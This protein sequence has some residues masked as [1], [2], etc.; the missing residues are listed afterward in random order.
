MNQIP[1]LLPFLLLRDLTRT[2]RRQAIQTLLPTTIPGA[3]QR[4]LLST[5]MVQRQVE[6]QALAE[7]RL[8][9]EALD[10]VKASAHGTL[11]DAAGLAEFPAINAAFHKLSEA[12]RA[13]FFPSVAEGGVTGGVEGG[14]VRGR[15]RRPSGD[16]T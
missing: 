10:A 7:E 1:A 15:G 13:E 8:T 16:E 12:E 3:G 14:A 6:E 2:Q 9:T 4:L 11:R 5:V